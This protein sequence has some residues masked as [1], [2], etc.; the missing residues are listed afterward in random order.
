MA[1][2]LSMSFATSLGGKTSLTLDEPIDGLTET[3]VRGVMETIISSNV[4]DSSKG[5]LTEVKAAKVV[6]TMTETLI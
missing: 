2:K 3:A 6:T 1:K 5:D 4:F